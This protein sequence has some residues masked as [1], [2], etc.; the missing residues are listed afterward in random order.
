MRASKKIWV[1]TDSR[2]RIYNLE[3]Q[4]SGACRIHHIAGWA[5][6][7]DFAIWAREV[8]V[9]FNSKTNRVYLYDSIVTR[10]VKR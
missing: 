8:N 6:K 4:T 7:K 3:D 10:L 2:G 9:G 1:I 5:T